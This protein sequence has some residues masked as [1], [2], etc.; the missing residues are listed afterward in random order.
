MSYRKKGNEI[1]ENLFVLELANNHWGSVERG[2]K[3]IYEHGSIARINNVKAAIKLQ[4]R[5][6]DE[7]I[8]PE[9]K[10]DQ[11][12]RYIKK[13]EQTKLSRDDF[14]VM[15]NK[16]RDMSCI[17]MST[18]FDE[19]SVDLCIE[20]DMPIIKIASSDVNDWPLISK[21]ASTRRPTIISS[22]G[23]S[24]KDLDDIV[25]YFA[26]RDIPLAINHCVSLYPSEDN[27]LELDQIDYLRNR[28]PD[29]VI[30]LSTHEYHDWSSSVLMSYAKGA[31]T[32]E[33]HVDI[34]YNG[35]PVSSYCSLPEQCDTWFKSYHKAV[36]MCGGRS[37]TR[38]V[39]SRKETE[40]LDQLVRG[41]YAKRDLQ[42][43]Y[44][45]HKDSFEK[46]FYLAIPLR[47][48]QLSCREIMNGETLT[49][50]IK[51]DEALTI[52]HID[53]P[54][55]TNPALKNLIKNRGL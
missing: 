22:G 38:R 37:T 41:A 25:T 54:Y 29:N 24:E 23:A 26:K 11:D 43:G 18:P 32:W 50:A 33:R 9:F 48:G 20:F 36:E 10:G 17:P 21:I 1:F 34:D 7:F 55:A 16:I 42:P 27:E 4:F 31:R 49:Q 5:D 2:L 15:V 35:V 52:D 14:A 30:G 51:A 3:I 45:I 44:K 6:V 47:K 12:N 28:Y 46:D 53:G 13:T 8:H 39:I 19:K 40:Y